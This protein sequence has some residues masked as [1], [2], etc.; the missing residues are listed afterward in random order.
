VNITFIVKTIKHK[1]VW[2]ITLTRDQLVLNVT[3]DDVAKARIRSAM[4]PGHNFVRETNA[5]TKIPIPLLHLIYEMQTCDINL[6]RVSVTARNISLKDRAKI[7][8][9]LILYY[10]NT[11]RFV[12]EDELHISYTRIQFWKAIDTDTLSTFFRQQDEDYWPLIQKFILYGNQK[13]GKGRSD[14]IRYVVNNS[15][16]GYSI[17]TFDN[18]MARAVQEGKLI[19]SKGYYSLPSK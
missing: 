17:D 9:L 16:F 4:S 13:R 2:Y 14:I 1:L 7:I 6:Q 19:Y 5:V 10:P 3:Y 15:R 12:P 8:F 11:F 18:V